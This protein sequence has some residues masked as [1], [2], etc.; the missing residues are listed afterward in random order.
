MDGEL[1]GRTAGLILDAAL[2]NPMT[3]AMWEG[4]CAGN[5]QWLVHGVAVCYAPTLE[6]L[7]RAAAERKTLI[8]SREHPFFLHGGF[9]Y[10]YGTGGLEAALKDDPVVQA[11]R[12]IIES[13]QLMVYRLGAAWDQFRPK[14][15]SAALARALGLTPLPS[16]PDD[17]ARGV[18]C[19]VPRTTLVELAQTAVDR[20]KTG[21]PRIVGDPTLSVSR[22]AVLAGETDPTPALAALLA[23]SKIDGVVAGAGGV[24]DEVDGALAYFRDVIGAGRKIAMLAVGFGPSHEP[25]VAEMARWLRDVFPGQ[26]VE[27][28]Q[29]PDPAWIPRA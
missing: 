6:I 3:T 20:L 24:V 18:V 4:L 8:V 13:G 29:T 28:W 15:Q 1:T 26:P 12:A 11:K 16:A 2:G 19:S 21:H 27:C 10:S 23:D 25:G 7:R 5:S 9:N 14:A 17:R 22:V